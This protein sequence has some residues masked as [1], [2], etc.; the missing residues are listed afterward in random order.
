MAGWGKFHDFKTKPCVVCGAEFTPKSG[1]HKFCSTQ[2][3]GKWKYITGVQS[4][5]NQY[6]KISGNWARYMARL[7]YFG[8]RK[9]ELSVEFLLDLLDRQGFRCALSGRELT[10]I[11]SK[12]DVALTNASIDRIHAGGSYVEDNVQLVCRGVN[13]WRSNISTPEFVEWC[14]SVAEFNRAFSQR[15]D[16]GKGDDNHG[17]TA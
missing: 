12:G 8:G 3:K 1:V 4:T 5:E 17:E 16:A 15:P 13:M 7:R 10:C 2:C 11:L 14:K 9:R 6:A